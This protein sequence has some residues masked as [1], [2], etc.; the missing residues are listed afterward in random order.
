MIVVGSSSI[1]YQDWK[2]ESAIV[3]LTMNVELSRYLPLQQK[4]FLGTDTF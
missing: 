2:S 4:H 3:P 1:Y